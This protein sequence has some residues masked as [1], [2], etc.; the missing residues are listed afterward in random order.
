VS[1][2][3][4]KEESQRLDAKKNVKKVFEQ[5]YSAGQNKWFFTP[6]RVSAVPR[7]ALSASDCADPILYSRHTVL[8]SFSS[9]HLTKTSSD[10]QHPSGSSACS[11][12]QGSIAMYRMKC[13]KVLQCRCHGHGRRCWRRVVQESLRRPCTFPLIHG[14]GFSHSQAWLSPLPY[15]IKTLRGIMQ[16]CQR[17]DFLYSTKSRIPPHMSLP[18]D[19]FTSQT[20]PLI[21]CSSRSR[22][23]SSI[24][25]S[26]AHARLST[27][28]SGQPLDHTYMCKYATACAWSP[29]A[30]PAEARDGEKDGEAAQ[31]VSWPGHRAGCQDEESGL[32]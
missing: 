17:A 9:L 29:E 7:P 31:A 15:P 2:E 24:N 25:I 27:I 5:K 3:T 1:A 28:L 20:A 4:L 11:S 26:T 21:V 8:N 18:S 10:P 6:L 32:E 22:P 19:L 16:Q 30:Y 13:R 12:F 23:A 14:Q